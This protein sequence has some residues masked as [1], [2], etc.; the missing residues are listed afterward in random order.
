[1]IKL[2]DTY[3]LDWDKL[4]F[5]LVEEK[6]NQKQVKNKETGELE[7]SENYG[8]KYYDNEGFYPKLS[9]LY[10]KLTHLHLRDG[11]M[12][13]IESMYIKFINFIR[14]IEPHD[15]VI[16]ELK[17]RICELEDE[18]KALKNAKE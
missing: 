11:D 6:T 2:T 5:I 4:N 14:N 10:S 8:Q 13:D 16:R 12:H 3:Y 18:V 17:N 7:N 1:M 15:K 9:Q